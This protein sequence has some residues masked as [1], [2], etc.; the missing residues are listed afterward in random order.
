MKKF[1][2]HRALGAAFFFCMVCPNG[3]ATQDGMPFNFQ[4]RPAHF[5]VT[6]NVINRA[7]E[8]FTV[9][10]PS[11]GN[12]LK[13]DA[14]DGFEPVT[15]RTQI[16]AG[17]N[18]VKRI[19][20]AHPAGIHHYNSWGSGYLDGA[21]VRVYRV[22][23]R[24]LKLVRRDRV[25]SGGT[26][27]EQWNISMERVLPPDASEGYWGWAPWS[28]PGTEDWFTVIAVDQAGRRFPGN[29]VKLRRPDGTHPNNADA[30]NATHTFRAD[31]RA[32]VEGSLT[33]PD[34]VH[35]VITDENLV[36]LTW[37]PSTSPDLAGYVLAQ[38]D[39]DPSG[40]RGVYLELETAPASE[41]AYI[42]EGD[43]II[44]STE[45]RAFDRRLLSHRL[46]GLD[47]IIRSYFPGNIPNGFYPY[48]VE[49]KTWT[50]EDHKPNTPVTEPGRTYLAMTLRDGD[51]EKIGKHGIPHIST[52]Q[53]DY[54]P[55][56]HPAEYIMEVWLKAD[57]D[58]APPVVFEHDGDARVGGF[59]TPYSMQ[60]STSWQKFEY[61]FTGR[62]ADQGHHAYFVLTCRG[63]A[64]YAVDNFRVYRADTP[65]LGLLPEE[66]DR[67]RESGMMAIRTHGPIKTGETTY[68]MDAF[69]RPGGVIQG[70]WRGNTLPQMLREMEKLGTRPWLQ[71]EYHMSPEEW[72]G[73][74]EYIAAPYDPAV[75]TPERKPWA[76]RRYAQGRAEPW[77]EA[78]D[79]IYFELA[80]ETWNRIFSPWIFHD[81]PDHGAG[82]RVARGE[83]YGMMH[84]YVVGLLRSSPYWTD[85]IDAKFKHVLGGWTISSYSREAVKGSQTGAFITIAAYNGGWDE[86]E[87]PPRKNPYSYF[88]TLNQANIT[89]SHR[90]AALADTVQYAAAQGKIVQAGTYEAGPGYAMNGLNG[91][92]VSREEAQEQEEVMKSK[93]AGVATLDAFLLQAQF[94]FALQNYFTFSEGER[95]TSHTRWW[96]GGRAHP[97]FLALQLFNKLGAG[98]LLQVE[99]VNVSTVNYPAVR[100]RKAQ[101]NAPLAALYA[102]QNGDTMTL[103]CIN[104][105]YPGFPEKEDDGISAFEVELPFKQAQQI[106]LY[107]MSGAITDHNLNDKRVQIERVALE[108]E[109]VLD[110]SGRFTINEPSQGLPPGE[111]HIYTFEGISH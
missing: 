16:M 44:I 25:A 95:W 75:D 67:Y 52:T 21:D 60:P 19:Y 103:F 17:S 1:G 4:K 13:R 15:F 109:N 6:T 12:T 78:F 68:S 69:T 91:A 3:Q 36:R 50:L 48:D 62:S 84:D 96:N 7:L 27:V 30:K 88:T 98:D 59:V 49:G 33:G 11:F 53:Q 94:G 77:T 87:G 51:V 28:R 56:P 5:R 82:Q 35:A 39:T 26:V 104:R 64:T 97:A 31:P 99:T 83:V 65:Y 58:D 32:P 23:N 61:R 92:R 100:R 29:A 22:Y 85:A 8:P 55:V 40:H 45:W 66:Q 9:T 57:R 54:Y 47:D 89:T 106:T 79:R 81:M 90:A 111:M 80:N 102:V 37:T 105:A 46:G 10:M 101:D 42:R 74:A 34:D 14:Q 71:I 107:R 73:F 43:L 24:A 18:A 86:G 108:T 2:K 76:A 93:L 41:E 20:S 38:S 72:L 63:P 70:I 110:G